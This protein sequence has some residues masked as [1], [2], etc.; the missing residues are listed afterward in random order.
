MYIINT[1]RPFLLMFDVTGNF[2]VVDVRILYFMIC[3]NVKNKYM[4]IY[5][6]YIT[7]LF[8]RVHGNERTC[9]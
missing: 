4:Y 6:T 7:F 2:T 3:C 5:K 1:T 8:D 9:F